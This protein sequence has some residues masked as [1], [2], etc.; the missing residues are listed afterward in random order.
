MAEQMFCY[1]CPE[2]KFMAATTLH[3]AA[4]H[5]PKINQKQ[6]NFS[7]DIYNIHH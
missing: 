2:Q 7:T 4:V 3:N 5:S 6:F 1:S